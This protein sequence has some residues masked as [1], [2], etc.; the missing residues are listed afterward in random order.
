MMVESSLNILIVDDEKI[1]H[2]TLE[3]YL[4]DS[5]HQVESAYNGNSALEMIENQDYDLVLV[6][7]KMPDMDGLEVLARTSEIKPD[8][9]VVLITGHGNMEMA[10]Q[11]LRLGAADF[12]SKPVKLLEL[13][14]VLEKTARIY[15]LCKMQRHLRDTITEIQRISDSRARGGTMIAESQALKEVRQQVKMAVEAGCDTILLTGETGAGKEVVAREIHF[16]GGHQNPFMAVSC[17]ALPESLVESELFGHTKGSFTGAAVDKAG[18]FELADEG[19][20][21]LDEVAD[22]SP[23][24]QAKLLRVLETRCVRRVGGAKEK[25]VNLRVIAATNTPL[26]ELVKKQKLRQDLYYRLNVFTINIPPLRERREDIMPLARHFLE[27]FIRDRGMNIDGFTSKA[28]EMLT[29][30]NFPGNVRELRNIIERAA[31]LTRSGVIGSEHLNLPKELQQ[32]ENLT[33]KTLKGNE[34][35]AIMLALKDSKWN[36]RQA[37]ENLGISYSTLR[38]KIKKYSIV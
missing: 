30:Y 9:P 29:G 21:L 27:S 38:Y 12:L 33:P 23:G 3:P 22:L 37:A 34:R 28:E 24:A 4:K 36:R 5:G 2:Q 35:D 15:E 10:I 7:V 14:A 26:E 8:L 19:T 6:D 13:D 32:S 31:I 17:P 18:Y 20:L 25:Q 11:S 16:M 1:V